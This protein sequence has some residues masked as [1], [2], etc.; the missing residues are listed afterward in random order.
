M[1]PKGSG[2][3]DVQKQEEEKA[4]IAYLIERLA[5]ERK[6]QC[7]PYLPGRGRTDLSEL[8]DGEWGESIVL[9][10]ITAANA[11]R[12]EQ[13]RG[14]LSNSEGLMRSAA[15]KALELAC[16]PG[17]TLSFRR[18]AEEYGLAT[19]EVRGLR[20][21]SGHLRDKENTQHASS[22]APKSTPPGSPAVRGVLSPRPAAPSPQQSPITNIYKH[23][24]T[25]AATDVAQARE[26]R[27]PQVHSLLSGLRQP[28]DPLLLH[29]VGERLR[30]AEM[31]QLL[32][33]HA[34]GKQGTSLEPLVAQLDEKVRLKLALTAMSDASIVRQALKQALS[35]RSAAKASGVAASS[36][37]PLVSTALLDLAEDEQLDV[38]DTLG[39]LLM[40]KVWRARN[41]R[42]S[43]SATHP[44]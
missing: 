31:A 7:L 33:G 29:E 41:R 39:E 26:A 1:P 35:T 12:T 40:S 28:A 24:K 44:I 21:N 2:A 10:L 4:L 6:E 36:V 22:P 5:S 27:Q 37:A 16:N 34:A 43:P 3:T 23:Q 25:R 17:D 19:S 9:G 20:G 18:R 32:N 13:G 30:P 42:V 11:C 14:L 8:C 38:L 15:F